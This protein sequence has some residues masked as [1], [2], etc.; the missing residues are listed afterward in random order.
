MCKRRWNPE[1]THPT[2]PLIAVCIV[3]V[4]PKKTLVFSVKHGDFEQLW[5][6]PGFDLEASTVLAGNVLQ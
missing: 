2:P 1:H 6:P 5:H 4:Q 3:H